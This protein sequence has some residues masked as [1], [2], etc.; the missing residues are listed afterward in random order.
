MDTAV[1]MP[2]SERINLRLIVFSTI[3]LL[4]LGYPTYVFVTESLT[5]GVRDH[6]TFKEVDLKAMSNFEMDQND[7]TLDDIPKTF[8]ALDGQRVMLEGEIYQPFS[9][10][11][12]V[13]GF[14][15]CYSIAKCCYSGPPKVQ[16]FVNVRVGEGKTVRVY[17]NLVR[18]VG[19]LHVKIEKENGKIQSVYS[20]D[21][22]T[23]DPL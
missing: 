16:H 19:I 11:D 15:L 9:A 18:V 12:K 14:Q 2:I 5:G 22:D 13:A 6:G 3:A 21:V 23:V 4:L 1:K 7:A 20:L 17:D 10:N 8:R